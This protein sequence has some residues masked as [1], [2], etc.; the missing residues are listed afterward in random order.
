MPDPYLRRMAS[1][2][3]ERIW[4]N[5]F[6][7]WS[8]A[9]ERITGPGSRMAPSEWMG[10]DNERALFATGVTRPIW[11]NMF[12]P[13]D[14]WDA[15]SKKGPGW[16]FNGLEATVPGLPDYMQNLAWDKTFPNE[17]QTGLSLVHWKRYP[18]LDA[19]LPDP[20]RP[21]K[22]VNYQTENY[23]I[24]STTSSWFVNTCVVA[25]SAW[26]NNSLSPGAPAGSPE[27][28]CLLYPH[29]VFNGMSTLDKG[30]IYFEKD[31]ENPTR[32]EKGGP[33]GPFLREFV[34]FGRV[35]TLQDRN[36][37]LLSYT[38]NPGTHN[39]PGEIL[40]K[41]KTQRASAGMFFFR[42][43]DGLE[44]I[45][46]NRQPVTSLPCELKPGDWW[47]IE[48]GDVY[49]AIRPL[50]ST[51]L[52]GDCKTVLEKRNH[53]IV[54]YQDNVNSDNILGI[55]DEQ[56]VK[57]RSGFIV[58]M[59]NSKEYGSFDK[60]REIVLAGKVTIDDD[61]SF[62]RHIA[63]QR[64]NRNM[65]MIWHSY[66]EDYAVRRISG[67]DDAWPRFAQSP[68]FAAGDN[69]ELSVKD[70]CAKTSPGNTQWLLSCSPS[71]TWVFYQS[72]F[73][74][75]LP[76][77]LT[78][79]AGNLKVNS[80]PF[81]KVVLTQKSADEV[82]VDIDAG[83]RSPRSEKSYGSTSQHII[84]LETPAKKISAVINGITYEAKLVKK[85]GNK[86][87]EISPFSKISELEQTMLNRPLNRYE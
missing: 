34:E 68:E 44:G 82:S 6:L 25:A 47:F 35:G 33:G 65:E 5:R 51:P 70:A 56:W 36:T 79:P 60:F 77:D 63:Y 27:R 11:V 64:E 21:A 38:P 73:D 85:N 26:W 57:A 76:V 43:T 41:T 39:I 37:L 15:R 45:Y 7:T 71:K 28:F 80:L 20:N 67:K 40:V 84:Y 29:Y 1:M 62:E 46:V 59:G 14:G 42:W 75:E 12:F 13:W 2:I 69:G 83:Y 22:Y 48:D 8:S 66:R 49:A 61:D 18:P 19:A 55:T 10:T 87:W 53:H 24:G 16:E 86:V 74:K 72:Q 31:P 32:D 50:T 4:I 30:N 52:K 81:G 78:C 23:T 54:L 17:L 3:A 9:V 58:E